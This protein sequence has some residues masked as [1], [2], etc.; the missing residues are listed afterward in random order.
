MVEEAEKLRARA[1]HC[2]ELAAT[3]MDPAV[4]DTLLV[5]AEEFEEAAAD[6]ETR[7]ENGEGYNA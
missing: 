1:K 5:M 3:A 2:R 4:E 6:L 7:R